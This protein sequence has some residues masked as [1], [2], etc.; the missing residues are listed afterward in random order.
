MSVKNIS[1]HWSRIRPRHKAPKLGVG[2]IVAVLVLLLLIWWM[3]GCDCNAPDDP[4]A[5]VKSRVTMVVTG[6]CNCGSCCGWRRNWWKLGRPEYDYGPLKGKPKRIGITASGTEAKLG[7]IAADPKVFPFGTRLRV[8]GYGVGTVEDIGGAIQ[9]R[10]IDLWFPSHVTARR[11]GR[12]ELTI[13]V[14]K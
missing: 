4:R 5:E 3:G 1:I 8:P 13:E 14:L 9:G 12:K 11:W 6:Y 7:T 2:A 10:H